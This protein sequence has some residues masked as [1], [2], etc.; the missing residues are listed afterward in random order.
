M[1]ATPRTVPF[2]V[3][4]RRRP[5]RLSSALETDKDPYGSEGD[6]RA[7]MGIPSR[8]P[9]DGNPVLYDLLKTYSLPPGVASIRRIA[10]LNGCRVV[11]H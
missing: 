11:A 9:P 5:K 6:P 4:G 7:F 3:L 1:G 2:L 10:P 8:S